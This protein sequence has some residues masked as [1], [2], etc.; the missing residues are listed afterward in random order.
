M[1][2][3]LLYLRN[4]LCFQNR[5]TRVVC[6]RY[7]WCEGVA[8]FLWGLLFLIDHLERGAILMQ[9]AAVSLQPDGLVPLS[10]HWLIT[11]RGKKKQLHLTTVCTFFSLS[12]N[13]AF[14]TKIYLRKMYLILIYGVTLKIP[15]FLHSF[16]SFGSRKNLLLLSQSKLS[17]A[18]KWIKFFFFPN[19]WRRFKETLRLLGM[20][21]DSGIGQVAP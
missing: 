16:P 18:S 10:L 14:V 1:P 13:L 2:K 6:D 21:V 12:P 3:S 19:S 20:G 17:A 11:F 8:L 15:F 9:T 7:K 5:S 4:S